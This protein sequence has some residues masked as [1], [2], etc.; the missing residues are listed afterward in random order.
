MKKSD[1]R[2]SGGAGTVHLVCNAHLDPVWL[3]EW[4]EGASEAVST[5]RA[6]ADFCEEFHGFIFNHNEALL[7]QW[8]E[9]YDPELFARIC[10]LVAAG[11]WHVTGG[12]F[13]QPD[14]NMPSGEALL[15]QARY[16][17][18]YF[19]ERLGVKPLA[20]VNFDSFGHSRGIVT[21]LRACGQSSYVF[22]RPGRE[23]LHLPAHLFRWVGFD[24]G[25]V[26]A[27][28]IPGH[29]NSHLGKVR[30][31]IERT[32]E[33]Y[34]GD[35]DWPKIVLWGVGN[36]GGGAS[37]KD[38]NDLSEMFDE[39]SFPVGHSTPDA[40][41][42]ELSASGHSLPRHEDD[43]NSW[44]VGCYTSQAKIKQAYRRLENTMFQVE[45]MCAAAVANSLMEYPERDF[46]EAL[47]DLLFVQFH[48][49][50]PGSSIAPVE[51][52]CLQM[53]GHAMEILRRLRARAFFALC[54]G[55][56]PVAE[57]MI[58]VFVFNP[59][60]HDVTT[61]VSCEFQ[62]PDQN[63]DRTWTVPVVTSQGKD[64]PTNI[65]KEE[66]NLNLDWRKKIVF[67]ATLP[68]GQMSRFDCRLE[69]REERPR[70]P[71]LS[72]QDKSIVVKTKD[73]RLSISRRT[74]LLEYIEINGR[75]MLK[76][77]AARLLVM[78]DSADPWGM[79]VDSFRKKAGSFKLASAK[80][81]AEI[82]GV[83]AK[84]LQ[85]VRIVEAGKA[86]TVIEATFEFNRSHANIHYEIPMH[87]TACTIA[88][89]VHWMESDK[90]LKL[91]LP[92]TLENPEYLGETAWGV[93]KLPSG[94]KEAVA[95]RWTAAVDAKTGMSFSVINDGTYGS[96]FDKGEIRMS[97]LRSPAYSAHPIADKAI[98][99]S[100]RH[101]P[102][103][104]RGVRNFSFIL[105]A[106]PACSHVPELGRKADEAS[107]PPVALPFCPDGSGNKPKPFITFD[108]PVVI[109]A[110]ITPSKE[111]G[112]QWVARVFNPSD[113][114]QKC[115]ASLPAINT[116]K[117]LR[118]KPF[119]LMELS[120]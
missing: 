56:S 16:G 84:T 91:S 29:Y 95:Q 22:C 61:L 58:P 70:L 33:A 66:S 87:G 31:K 34:P 21:V 103:I 11:R 1:R 71:E 10:A 98:I 65:E 108:N 90:F 2:P 51:E 96:D 69:T 15:R 106:G 47:R 6:A 28:R 42:T 38:I 93:Q 111:D 112:A 88:I 30:E 18:E 109:C 48:D 37:R 4:E 78:K 101:I 119:Q 68:A 19:R 107:Q 120:L 114:S 43:L 24:G 118:L 74:G 26:A 60:P 59:H 52:N 40:F 105:D 116:K 76:P 55:Q 99:P 85:P 77:G 79:R 94:G 72:P 13:L 27:V 46:K 64:L 25:E 36:H 110:S 75:N 115:T 73:L 50:L 62:L 9:E 82:C 80:R 92:T 3:W 5:F 117:T 20:G 7:Y 86:R 53:M 67:E 44:A 41:F 17:L 45:K 14:C 32:L 81:A 57:G 49:I 83:H 23:N 54:S 12:W 8:V 35:A 89:N 97:L 102:R 100:D 63:H 39:V 113:S 104:D